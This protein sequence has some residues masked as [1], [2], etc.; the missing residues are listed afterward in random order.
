MGKV[1]YSSLRRTFKSTVSGE[2][3]LKQNYTSRV[4]GEIFF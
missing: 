4:D 2:K 1:K 3:S